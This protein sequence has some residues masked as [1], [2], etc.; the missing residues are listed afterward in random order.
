MQEITGS[1]FDLPAD[2]ICITTNGF[3]NASSANTMGRGSAGEAKHRYPGIQM[4]V[5]ERIRKYGNHVFLLTDQIER[6]EWVLQT[7]AAWE[8]PILSHA[9]ISFPTK[10]HWQDPSILKLIEQ[11]A[12]EL[13]GLAQAF[14]LESV[15]LPRAG[16]GPQT[17]QL[18]WDE[19]R[20]MLDGILDDRFTAVTFK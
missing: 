2:A 17:G 20:P 4:V 19:V 3:I 12:E 18:S 9:L 5:G 1:L 8:N 10:E 16:C 14:E 11:S 13:L 6:G 7:P 15:L